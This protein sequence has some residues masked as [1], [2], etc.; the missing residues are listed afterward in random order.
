MKKALWWR[1]LFFNSLPH[2]LKYYPK[3]LAKKKD[4]I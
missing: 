2:Q 3:K 4:F 1:A